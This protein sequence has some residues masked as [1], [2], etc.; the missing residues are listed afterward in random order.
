MKG[1]KYW[2]SLKAGGNL[3]FSS[4]MISRTALINSPNAV[5]VKTLVGIQTPPTPLTFS[6]DL[7]DSEGVRKPTGG[8]SPPPEPPR[9]FATAITR[10]RSLLILDPIGESVE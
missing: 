8:V 1:C 9:V 10:G 5:K 4:D 3:E 6:P 2:K 7:H